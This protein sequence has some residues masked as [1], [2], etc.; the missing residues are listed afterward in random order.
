MQ[1]VEL[2]GDFTDFNVQPDT[3]HFVCHV[4]NSL[5]F[6]AS[7]AIVAIQNQFPAAYDEYV[8]WYNYAVKGSNIPPRGLAKCLGED[9]HLWDL[10][11]LQTIKVHSDPNGGSIYVCNMLAQK[12]FGNVSGMP[13]GRYEA[14][15]ECLLKLRVCCDHVIEKGKK[16]SIEACK[17]GGLRAGLSWN[18]IFEMVQDIFSETEGVWNT[19]SYEG[20]NA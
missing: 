6:G 5:G 8:K 15:E 7:G 13:P 2:S 19:Y 18:V 10:G 3:T 20:P 17:F 16:V 4:V 1:F 14:I 11:N 9:N 12:A